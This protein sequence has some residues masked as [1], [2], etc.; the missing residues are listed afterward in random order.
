MSSLK[1]SCG[2]S[3]RFPETQELKQRREMDEWLVQH[4][5]TCV[6]MFYSI[7]RI[8]SYTAGNETQE[9]K[10]YVTSKIY[11]HRYMS[12]WLSWSKFQ[13]VN[14]SGCA[15]WA[16][17]Q[18]WSSVYCSGIHSLVIPALSGLDWM[19]QESKNELFLTSSSL[20]HLWCQWKELSPSA[21][22]WLSTKE[23]WSLDVDMTFIQLK[24][25]EQ[26]VTSW[27]HILQSFKKSLLPSNS[28]SDPQLSEGV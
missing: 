27:Y 7:V 23:S 11:T 9:Y 8:F 25:K 3:I 18:L 12:S 13:P 20:E 21:E 10:V 16:L 4:G 22:Q 19:P 15:V 17:G 5:L 2:F 14:D 1:G 6:V 26:S 28:V 24:T